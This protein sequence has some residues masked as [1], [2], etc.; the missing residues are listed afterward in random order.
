MTQPKSNLRPV[1]SLN[2]KLDHRLAAYVAVA[3]A[4]GFGLMAAPPGAEAK[5]VYTSTNVRIL[6]QS[7]IDL[8]NDGIADFQFVIR[9]CGSHSDCLDVNPLAK[10]NGM[11]GKNSIV[12]AGFF[13]VPV[14]AGEN[15]L[16]GEGNASYGNFMALGGAYGSYQWSG[17]PWANTTNRYL[18]VRF[19]ISG[20]T[21]YGWARLS[22]NMKSGLI[23]LSGY[24][25]ETTPNRTIIEG[26]ISGPEIA[27]LSPDRVVP[28]QRPASLGAL[29]R[30]ADGLDLWRREEELSR[31]V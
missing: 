21:H 2:P 3:S 11:R 6:S 28:F 17:G 10:G 26:H 12:N 19:M 5:V 27:E 25:Y 31:S 1:S 13:G 30:G 8:N 23:K 7:T 16:V 22:V 9:E 18:G 20:Q 15:F 24:A 29:A 14:G 4:A